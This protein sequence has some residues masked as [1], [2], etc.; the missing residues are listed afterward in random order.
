MKHFLLGGLSVISSQLDA[1]DSV[2]SC[3]ERAIC[4]DASSSRISQQKVLTPF[5]PR[6]EI[7]ILTARSRC[8]IFLLLTSYFSS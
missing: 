3:L 1:G 7:L 2:H 8:L 5:C 4:G 6:L